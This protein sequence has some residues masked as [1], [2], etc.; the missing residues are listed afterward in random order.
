ME[1]FDDAKPRKE[2]ACLTEGPAGPSCADVLPRGGGRP[3]VPVSGAGAVQVEAAPPRGGSRRNPVECGEMPQEGSSKS[4]VT[5]DTFTAF[6]HKK[7]TWVRSG[8]A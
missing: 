8:L 3:D 4:I 7:I 2:M 5:V 6:S 1:R